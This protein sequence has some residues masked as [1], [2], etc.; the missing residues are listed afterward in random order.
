MS[1]MFVTDF[2]ASCDGG[3]TLRRLSDDA[4]AHR[5]TKGPHCGKC[6][7]VV[8]EPW[9]T[10]MKP[11]VYPL[12]LETLEKTNSSVFPTSRL[13]CC[14]GLKAWMNELIVR[15]IYDPYLHFV[16]ESNSSAVKDGSI[17]GNNPNKVFQD[18]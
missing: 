10:Y 13:A 18:K 9:Y 4:P 15:V 2:Y 7:V 12:E 6:H 16:E 1:R 3:D 14:I 8:S 17:G 5:V 11:K